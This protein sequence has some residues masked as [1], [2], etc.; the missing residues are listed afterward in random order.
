M[1]GHH[2][3]LE[4][5]EICVIRASN[6]SHL[7]IWAPWTCAT[8]L[9]FPRYRSTLITV[10][11]GFGP[12]PSKCAAEGPVWAPGSRWGALGI[13]CLACA[14]VSFCGNANPVKQRRQSE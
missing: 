1:L 14:I 9:P 3:S 7:A 13:F 6:L 2:Q 10:I 5:D 12:V 11:G 4:L 8:C